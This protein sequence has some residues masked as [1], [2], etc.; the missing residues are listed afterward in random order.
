MR[1]YKLDM[2]LGAL[3]F[4]V[5]LASDYSWAPFSL[6]GHDPCTKGEG[7]RAMSQNQ[8][9]QMTVISGAL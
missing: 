2:V 7:Y 5:H 1:S 8:Q 9:C 3:S 6:T 4:V